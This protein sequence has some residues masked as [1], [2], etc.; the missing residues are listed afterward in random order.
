MY[1]LPAHEFAVHAYKLDGK[2]FCEKFLLDLDCVGDDLEDAGFRGFVDQVLE[3]Q[4][5]EVA[6]ETLVTRNQFVAE[7][8]T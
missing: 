4:A 1:P 6:M 7:C 8:E 5:G 3:H 2:R